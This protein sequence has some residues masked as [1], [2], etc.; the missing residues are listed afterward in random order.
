MDTSSI[1]PLKGLG[2]L[3]FGA[4]VQ[5]VVSYLGRPPEHVRNWLADNKWPDED[6]WCVEY[7]RSAEED[8]P[9]NSWDDRDY[10]LKYTD[11]MHLRYLA[12]IFGKYEGV[13][14][15][16]IEFAS[17]SHSLKL[18]G[19]QIC[20][21]DERDVV[22]NLARSGLVVLDSMDIGY[23]DVLRFSQG[24]H[25]RVRNFEIWEVTWSVFENSMSPLFG[26]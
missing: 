19:S 14:N 9:E 18:A 23:D 5:E 1:I 26:D 11:K 2:Q 20:G 10:E 4:S 8:F 12:V 13:P 16:L 24:V 17:N 21:C 25:L 6:S 15:V 3:R 22:P 7:E